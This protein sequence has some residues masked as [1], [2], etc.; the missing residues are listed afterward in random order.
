MSALDETPAPVPEPAPEPVPGP[1]EPQ[2]L[3]PDASI[4]DRIGALRE[5]Q[6]SEKHLDL[7]VPA[8]QELVWLRFRVIP[9]QQTQSMAKR[10][11]K[12]KLADDALVGATDTLIA[13][14][15]Q[16]MVREQPDAELRAIDPAAATPI[17]LDSQLA[18][19]LKLD[20]STAREVVYRLF[21]N[22]Y[23]IVQMA[24]KVSR[25]M[26]DTSKEVDDDFLGES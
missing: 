13:A 9:F 11:Q 24:I 7:A 20:A 12:E 18:E 15:E 14:C 23:A 25:W 19:L 5:E 10:L 17:R 2:S 6:R 3:G 8:L 4:L 22:D 16:V 1:E 26:A 21:E